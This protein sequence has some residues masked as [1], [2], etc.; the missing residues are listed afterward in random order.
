MCSPRALSCFCAIRSG[1][2]RAPRTS[3]AP[4]WSSSRRRGTALPRGRR[5]RSTST[6]WISRPR[7]TARSPRWNRQRVRAGRCGPQTPSPKRG[8]TS[9]SMPA[10]S[11]TG[12]AACPRCSRT[13]A[14]GAQRVIAWWSSPRVQGRLSASPPRCATRAS[15]RRGATMCPSGV[16]ARMTSSSRPHAGR[17]ASPRRAGT[18]PSSRRPISSGS[19]RPCGM[20]R[21]CRPVV[22]APSTPCSSRPATWW[23]TSSTA[24]AVTSR[25][26]SGPSPM[27]P[28]ST[29]SSSTPHHAGVSRRTASTC[30]P[31]SSTR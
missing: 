1:S 21:A 6:G 25:W 5:R 22:A 2:A 24:S 11:R 20:R 4:R 3:C 13:S 29:S 7:R 28:A 16:Q 14:P 31:T 8:M 10:P 23:S 26:C 9:P 17:A 12:A 18:S 19:G 15:Q 27:P 30:R